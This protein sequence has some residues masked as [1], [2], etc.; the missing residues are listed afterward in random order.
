M[1]EESSISEATVLTQLQQMLRETYETL[2]F[3]KELNAMYDYKSTL[4]HFITIPTTLHQSMNNPL[5]LNWCKH[6]QCFS[7]VIAGAVH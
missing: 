7:V 4:H 3:S 2:C 6:A 5:Y 1:G